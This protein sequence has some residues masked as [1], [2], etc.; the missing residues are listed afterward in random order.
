MNAMAMDWSCSKKLEARFATIIRPW[1]ERF[2]KPLPKDKQYWTMCGKCFKDDGSRLEHCEIGQLLEHGL[3]MPSQFH[4]VDID[5]EVIEGNKKAWPNVD[6]TVGDFR[7][8]MLARRDFSPGIV[9]CDTTFR[10][11]RAAQMIG[12][13]MYDLDVVSSGEL[14]LVANVVLSIMGIMK[15]DAIRRLSKDGNFMSSW[16]S[17]R[18][19][20]YKEAVF[21]YKGSGTSNSTVMGSVVLFRKS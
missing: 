14:M 19:E 9:N 1:M 17:G 6:W 12:D 5:R 2:G 11:R 18:W 21:E 16:T 13:V 4:G 8:T 15:G 20:A 7:S 10:P 3:I